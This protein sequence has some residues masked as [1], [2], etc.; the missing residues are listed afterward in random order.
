MI[1]ESQMADILEF[2]YTDH[3]QI[4]TQENAK[5]LVQ[6]A[7]YLLLPNLKVVTGKYLEEHF[8]LANCFSIY[9]LAEKYLCQNLI[10]TCRKFIHSNFSSVAQS[11]D[12]SSHEVEKMDFQR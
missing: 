2:I 4:S 6:L 11:G 8:T 9:H 1:L 10:A 7:D 12:F 5:T 3:V